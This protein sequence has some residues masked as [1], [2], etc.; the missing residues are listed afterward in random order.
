[1][2]DKKP[3]VV[4]D[5]PSKD[6]A[7]KSSLYGKALTTLKANHKEEF[8]SILAGLYNEK[9][10]T[11]TPRLT[12][13]ERKLK[14]LEFLAAELGVTIVRSDAPVDAEVAA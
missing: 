9:G 12:P 6:A 13:A 2:A 3:A 14:E 1:M 7:L 4:P 10:L 8:D 11:Y 5:D